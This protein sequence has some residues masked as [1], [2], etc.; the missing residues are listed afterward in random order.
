V[1][2]ATAPG[3]A[4]L[5][6]RQPKA[7]ARGDT[8]GRFRNRSILRFEQ[9]MASRIMPL[10]TVNDR[11]ART[12]TVPRDHAHAEEVAGRRFNGEERRHE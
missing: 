1:P 8:D 5:G 9:S 10:A 2:Q 3:R 7:V 11:D 4:P 12:A 6:I